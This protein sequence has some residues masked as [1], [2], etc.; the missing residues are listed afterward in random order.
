MRIPLRILSD[1]KLELDAYAICGMTRKSGP[2]TF[3]VD[4][5]SEVS[6]IG[7]KDV[8][9]L[10]L[11]SKDLAKYVGRPI[12]GIG[13]RA[14]TLVVKDVTVIFGLGQGEEIIVPGRDFLYHKPVKHKKRRRRGVQRY[15]EVAVI[16]TPSIMGMDLL[17][18]MGLALYYDPKN[19]IAYLEKSP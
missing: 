8:K 16:R 2:V 9:S 14:K 11:E 5:G 6:S 1:G 12:A 3:I 13:G 15:E 4:T 10:G 7:E 19:G 18:N 17:K